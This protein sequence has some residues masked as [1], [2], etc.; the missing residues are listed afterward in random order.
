MKATS[1]DPARDYQ[2]GVQVASRPGAGHRDAMIELPAALSAGAAKRLAEGA[3]ARADRERER[4]M[5]LAGWRALAL[6]PGARV[7]IAGEPGQ[8]RID[9]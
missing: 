9:R 1:I 2:A 6:P 4:R 7:R 5:V 3:L 8:W